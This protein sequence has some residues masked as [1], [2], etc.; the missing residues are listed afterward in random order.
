MDL[1]NLTIEF[2]KALLSFTTDVLGFYVPELY[3]VF[4]KS[5]GDMFRHAVKLHLDAVQ[6]GK[7]PQDADFIHDNAVYLVGT[8]LLAVGKKI[9]E[10]L[11]FDAEEVIEL[12]DQLKST[13][14]EKRTDHEDDGDV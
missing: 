10:K 7:H 5:F 12:H 3:T 1:T 9:K 4:I 13:L 11:G 6:S 2:C 14:N 8:V